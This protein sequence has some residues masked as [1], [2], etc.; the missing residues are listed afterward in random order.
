MLLLKSLIGF[1]LLSCFEAS[2]FA[3]PTHRQMAITIDDLP[4]T[5]ELHC[6][7]QEA[8]TSTKKLL[9]PI[10]TAKV[11]VVGFVVGVRCGNL[12]PEQRRGL[13]KM[14]LDVG[15]ELG[16]HTW[17]HPD[18]NRVS[19]EEYEKQIL[20]TDK[21]LHHT[22]SSL[23]LRY[24]R[25]P[26]LHDGATPEIKK[27]LQSFLTEHGYQE[28]PVTFDNN[29]WMFAAAYSRALK[30]SNAALAKL[31]EEAYMP[32]MES[33]VAFFEKRSVEVLGRE[34][35]QVL[36]LHASRLN[37]EMMPRLL[38]M[39]RERGYTFVSLEQAMSDEAYRLPDA[40]V[41]E[42]GLSWIH[43]WG[44][45]NGKPIQMEPDEPDWIRSAIQLRFRRPRFN[46][47]ELIGHF[48]ED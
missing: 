17:S 29:D 16:N 12:N 31:I 30:K 23:K 22:F 39:F 25:A 28:A 48:S 44:L 14:W 45:T 43:R 8:L 33:I 13:L 7:E 6:N 11:P 34:C 40:Y 36:L 5:D 10:R 24:F 18:L 19:L 47:L 42:K 15:A 46:V 41:G 26:Y 27:K 20:A 2:A 3:Q 21:D 9:D 38:H 4:Y 37:A 32:Y 1:W 35:P